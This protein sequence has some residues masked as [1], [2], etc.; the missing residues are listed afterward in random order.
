MLNFDNLVQSCAKKRPRV[1]EEGM[2]KDT[3]TRGAPYADTLYFR[4]AAI[5]QAVH[6]MYKVENISDAVLDRIEV[7]VDVRSCWVCLIF[8]SL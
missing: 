8:P 4:L 7:E 6:L 3:N 5:H 1:D 2:R